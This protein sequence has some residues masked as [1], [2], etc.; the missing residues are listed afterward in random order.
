MGLLNQKDLEWLAWNWRGWN[1]QQ[2]FRSR[3]LMMFGHCNHTLGLLPTPGQILYGIILAQVDQLKSEGNSNFR[4]SLPY[5]QMWKKV[6]AMVQG[7]EMNEPLTP[8]ILSDPSHKLVQTLVYI[9]SMQTFIFSEMNKA[10]RT[11]DIHKIKFYGPL[12]SALSMIIHC[13]NHKNTGLPAE[14]SVYRGL[15]I[16]PKEL[17]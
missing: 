3:R 1:D 2:R 12:A 16:T 9:Y 13:G 5:T 6:F 7:I 15:Q 8:K 4:C 10:S 17:K 14:F 11:K